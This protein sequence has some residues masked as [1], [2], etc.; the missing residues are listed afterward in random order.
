MMSSDHRFSVLIHPVNVQRYIGKA[1]KPSEATGSSASISNDLP[2]MTERTLTASPNLLNNP[3]SQA[4][5]DLQL[6]EEDPPWTKHTPSVKAASVQQTR[7]KSGGINRRLCFSLDEKALFDLHHHQDSS[8][9]THH[10]SS[11]P[12][13]IAPAPVKPPFLAPKRA[14][15]PDGVPSWPGTSSRRLLRHEARGNAAQNHRARLARALAKILGHQ[16][17]TRNGKRARLWLALGFRLPNIDRV[18]SPQW[19]PPMSGHST[20]RF[21]PWESHPFN[22]PPGPEMQGCF[23][24]GKRRP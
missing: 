21:S 4:T 5:A 14:S 8:T 13:D 12:S 9:T 22:Q 23:A 19:R 10:R 18:T 20:F 16:N 15:T 17:R 3:S 7:R 6:K 2:P 11:I 1:Y 24:G